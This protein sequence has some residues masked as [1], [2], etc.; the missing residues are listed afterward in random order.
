MR[1]SASRMATKPCRRSKSK[2]DFDLI[3]SDIMMS[4]MDGMTL[5]ERTR[6]P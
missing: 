1:L 3:L 4:G 6:A 5:L 2:T